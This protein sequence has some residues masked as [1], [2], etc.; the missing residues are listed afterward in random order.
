RAHAAGRDQHGP[1]LYGSSSFGP[2]SG[3]GPWA[4]G[5]RDH[6]LDGVRLFSRP[7]SYAPRDQTRGPGGHRL[8]PSP[9]GGF[10]VLHWEGD[11]S[12]HRNRRMA[13]AGGDGH[14]AVSMFCI[15]KEI[16]PAIVRWH[17]PKKVEQFIRELCHAAKDEDPTA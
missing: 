5:H 4:A 6:S 3:P 9:S 13:M 14:P 8:L 7:I 11:P 16:P 2:R 17:G 1:H 10:N 12:R 15:G